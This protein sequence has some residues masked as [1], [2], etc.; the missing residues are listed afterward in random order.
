[1]YFLLFEGFPILALA[2]FFA[3]PGSLVYLFLQIVVPLF[4][5]Y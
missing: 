5:S 3:D 1:M 4:G 2:I